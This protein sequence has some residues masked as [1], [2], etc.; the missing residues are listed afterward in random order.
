MR[1]TSSVPPSGFIQVF[2]ICAMRSIY[3][4]VSHAISDLPYLKPAVALVLGFVGI[5]MFAEFFHYKIGIG[6]SLGVVREHA[7]CGSGDLFVQGN[8]ERSDIV[9]RK[10]MF[11]FR[12]AVLITSLDSFCWCRCCRLNQSSSPQLWS[13]NPCSKIRKFIVDY[14]IRTFTRLTVLRKG[15]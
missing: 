4:L 9:R 7:A 6:A 5:K 15:G 3:T 13:P 2:A 10:K 12:V 11:L 8:V 14:H 1:H